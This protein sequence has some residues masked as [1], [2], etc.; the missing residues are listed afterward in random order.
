VGLD[1][2]TRPSPIVETGDPD[3]TFVVDEQIAAMTGEAMRY[4]VI[5]VWDHQGDDDTELIVV[6]VVAGDV[7]LV[8]IGG[9]TTGD[10]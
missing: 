10:T 4:K 9:Q 3:T 2:K 1:R 6:G 8:D 7:P 5:G